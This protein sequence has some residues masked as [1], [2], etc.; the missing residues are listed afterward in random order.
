[1]VG[2]A[3]KRLLQGGSLYGNYTLSHFYTLHTYVLPGTILALLG[4]HLYLFRR[5]GV[6]PNW[7]MSKEQLVKKT[8]PFWRIGRQAMALRKPHREVSHQQYRVRDL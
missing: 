3:L 6:T 7:T 8:Q 4:L 2:P 1:M 5:H